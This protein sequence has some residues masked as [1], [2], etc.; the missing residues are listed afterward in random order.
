[1]KKRLIC[2]YLERNKFCFHKRLYD[3]PPNKNVKR[4]KKCIYINHPEKCRMY[5]QWVECIKSKI[6]PINPLNL[7]ILEDTYDIQN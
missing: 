4:R 7:A 6:K 1:M 5:N 3:K 2:P